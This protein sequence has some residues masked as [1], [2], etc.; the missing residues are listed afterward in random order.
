M[1]QNEPY[2]TGEHERE[3]DVRQNQDLDE[4]GFFNRR[5]FAPRI[6]PDLP[7]PQP[8]HEA[9]QEQDADQED[10]NEDDKRHSK[11]ERTHGDQPESLYPDCDP[12][13]A[14]PG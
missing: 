11:V 4:I 7:E 3:N 2:P 14:Y 12:E 8:C 10:K 1:S 6:Q 9:D 13:E 5:P